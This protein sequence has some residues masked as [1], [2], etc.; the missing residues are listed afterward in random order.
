MMVQGD[1]RFPGTAPR[2]STRQAGNA[3]ARQMGGVDSVWLY[4]TDNGYRVWAEDKAT[5]EEIATEL[6]FRGI[7]PLH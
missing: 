5:A 3:D 6:S 1:F 2:Y 4:K 7:P